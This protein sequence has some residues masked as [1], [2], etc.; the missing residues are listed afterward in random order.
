MFPSVDLM[1]NRINTEVIIRQCMVSI[2]MGLINNATLHVS[3]FEYLN[4]RVSL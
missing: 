3:F 2:S 4:R 1:H